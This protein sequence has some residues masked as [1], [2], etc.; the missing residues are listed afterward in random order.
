VAESALAEPLHMPKGRAGAAAGGED[1]HVRVFDLATGEPTASFPVAR[2]A[3]N[4]AQFH[5]S[6]P[7][8]ATASGAQRRLWRHTRAAS[9]PEVK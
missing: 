6:L 4:G 5:P 1:G 2:D 9:L 3:V 7:L 8:L